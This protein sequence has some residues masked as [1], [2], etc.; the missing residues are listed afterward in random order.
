M[1][2]AD[3]GPLAESMWQELDVLGVHG[4][5]KAMLHEGVAESFRPVVG[6]SEFG[7]WALAV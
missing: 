7:Q 6:A 4:M 1:Q 3:K 2:A 5:R